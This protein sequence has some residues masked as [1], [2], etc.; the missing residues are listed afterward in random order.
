MKIKVCGMTDPAQVRQLEEA[1]VELAGF[2]FY[3][4][5]PRYLPNFGLAP[6]DFKKEKFALAKVG[7]FVNASYDK[8]MKTVNDY[9]LDRVQLHG[10]ETPEECGRIAQQLPV[11]KA[12]RFGESEDV[13]ELLGNYYDSANMFLFDTGMAAPQGD[14]YKAYGGT[15]KKFNWNRLSGLNIDKPFFLSGGI[16]PGDAALIR[17]FMKEPVAKDLYAL[18]LNSRFEVSPGVKDMEKVRRFVNGEW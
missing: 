7:V 10:N 8:I 3:P 13:K 6:Q 16:E 2:I 12:F 18:D 1:G 11:I 5:S 15:G 14:S 9:G 17:A 4:E